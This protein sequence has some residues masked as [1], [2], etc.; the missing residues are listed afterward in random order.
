VVVGSLL[1]GACAGGPADNAS[2]VAT[3]VV[4]LPPSY[5][6]VPAAII[7]AVDTTVT[8]T[9]HDNFSHTVDIAADPA[10]PLSMSPGESVTYAFGSAGTF[11]YVCSLHPSDMAGSVIVTEN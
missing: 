2:P 10:A 8:W 1:L 9:N 7:V 5:K 6:F 11:E 4:D 3:S